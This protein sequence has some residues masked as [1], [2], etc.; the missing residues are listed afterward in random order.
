VGG[1]VEGCD[2]EDPCTDDTCDGTDGCVHTPNTAPC[3]DGN[4]CTE[5]D[6]C[7]D[8][9]CESGS[10]VSCF[11]DNPCTLDTCNL[12]I[13]CVNV[14]NVN[15]DDGIACT[16]D[17]CTPEAGCI[18]TPDN[19]SC[20]SGEQCVTDVCDISAGCIS[21]L[22]LNC[23]GNGIV[24][25][26]EECDD[27]NIDS[28][29]G[30]DANCIDENV[31][32]CFDDWLVGSP[33]NGTN[34]GN[35]CVPQDTGYHYVGEFDGYACWWHHKNQAWNTTPSSNFW[36]LAVSFGVTPGVG[37]CGWCFNK[38][39]IPTPLSMDN[40]SSYFSSSNTGAWGWCAE[41]DPN[42]VGFVCL[43]F[44]GNESCP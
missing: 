14:P 1:I 2:D 33:C 11:D 37:K 40:C 8:G 20:S 41:S 4:A 3:E 13:G 32:G 7:I 27:S 12:S 31:G 34:Y 38:F 29:D 42:S 39:S 28:G 25:G 9:T 43:P 10:P 22:T 23:C 30:C 36:S 35:G 18:H 24:E 16:V 44:Q 17:T 6:S 21:D 15:C 26:E 19:G 5:G